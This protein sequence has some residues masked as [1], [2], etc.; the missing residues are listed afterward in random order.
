MSTE[1]AVIY[2]T[3]LYRIEINSINVDKNSIDVYQVV[4]IK[5]GIS[6]AEIRTLPQALHWCDDLTARMEA[7]LDPEGNINT[8]LVTPV[9]VP[10]PTSQDIVH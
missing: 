7:V 3:K 8:T 1:V 9:T 10:G 2:E 6:E 4:N 5:T